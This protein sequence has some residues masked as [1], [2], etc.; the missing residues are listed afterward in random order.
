MRITTQMLNETAKRTGIPVCQNNLL[1]YINNE[2]SSGQ[3]TLLDSL[4][5]K[6][7][8]KVSSAVMSNYKKLDK[9]ASNLKTQADKLAETGEQSFLEKI[10][11]SGDNTKAYDTVQSYVDH[12]NS[13]LSGLKKSSGVLDRYYSEMLQDAANDQ[14]EQLEKI[15][16]TIGK[17]GMLSVDKEKLEAASIEDIQKAFGTLASK[18]SHIADRVSNNAQASME[19][20]SNQ[21]NG[22]GSIMSQLASR[23]DFW[24]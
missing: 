4:D 21:Y 10:K 19:S 6:N 3:N 1:S 8:D 7:K 5:K 22:T 16:V 15:G 11:E 13:T 17:D 14:S 23:Y 20:T 18:T 24:G 2:S 12:Y 9:D